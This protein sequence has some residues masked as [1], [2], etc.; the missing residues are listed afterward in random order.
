MKYKHIFFDLDHTLWDFDRCSGETLSELYI[1]YNLADCGK[2]TCDQFVGKFIE[3]NYKLWARFN[4]GT[5][6]K[7]G[8]RKLRFRK[9]FKMLDF[10]EDDLA[11]VVSE[12]YVSTCCK[13]GYLMPH[14]K[15]ILMYLEGK[16]EM[17][18]ITNGFD[19]IQNIKLES[20]GIAKYFGEIITS[21]N[22]GFRKP[23]KGI[24]NY[25]FA[26]AKCQ[27]SNAI[28]IGDNLQADMLG[29]SNSGLDTI[30]YNPAKVVF[31]MGVTHE[32]ACLSEIMDIL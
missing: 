1:K 4:A 27:V 32:I 24:F 16:Y 31:N 10:K 2:F 12:D 8:L 6:S 21:E 25:A 7:E 11:L 20:A 5:I 18:I 26:R 13:K 14:A 30:F 15:E 28:M 19:D 29:A 9:I 17:H 3:I 22:A 23:E